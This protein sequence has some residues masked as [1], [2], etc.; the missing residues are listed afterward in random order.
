[1]PTGCRPAAS[2]S[3][4]PSSPGSTNAKLVHVRQRLPARRLSAG[5]QGVQLV[6]LRDVDDG[7][8]V[9]AD[10]DIH[11]STRLI[12]RWGDGGIDGVAA[13]L[14]DVETRLPPVADSWP[15]SRRAP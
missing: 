6:L 2:R 5:V 9:A 7:E 13:F 8:Q 1:M 3:P 12:P 15:P 4:G 10:S 11:R 14:Q